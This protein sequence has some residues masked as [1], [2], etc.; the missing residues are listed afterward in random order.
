MLEAPF[1]ARDLL[2]DDNFRSTDRLIV[3]EY[4]LFEFLELDGIFGWQQTDC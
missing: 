1:P 2:H 3:I 4:F